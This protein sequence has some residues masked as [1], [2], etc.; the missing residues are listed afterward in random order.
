[1]KLL[2]LLSITLLF[3]ILSYYK[4]LLYDVDLNKLGGSNACME[5]IEKVFPFIDAQFRTVDVII[6]DSFESVYYAFEN[7]TLRPD[8]LED[9]GFAIGYASAL[10]RAESKIL[11]RRCEYACFAHYSSL[12]IEEDIHDDIRACANNYLGLMLPFFYTFFAALLFHRQFVK[13]LKA[14]LAAFLLPTASL[15]VATCM[16]H[17]AIAYTGL[18]IVT[19]PIIVGQ[20]ID[21]VRV[22]DGWAKLWHL[23]CKHATCLATTGLYV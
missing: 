6:A 4:P 12:D 16:Y 23:S 19:L 7:F 8:V 10:T 15:L 11:D 17:R 13:S 5:R 21:V 1:M 20:S 3:G 2:T 18:S 22:H 14:S 9:S